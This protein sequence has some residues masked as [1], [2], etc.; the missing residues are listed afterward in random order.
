[1]TQNEVALSN[2]IEKLNIVLMDCAITMTAQK[3]RIELADRV[4]LTLTMDHNSTPN[5]VRGFEMARDYF[6]KYEKEL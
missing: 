3:K 5:Y 1:V 2:E 6:V 4:I